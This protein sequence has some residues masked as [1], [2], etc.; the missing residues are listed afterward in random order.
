MLTLERFELRLRQ[1]WIPDELVAGS[2]E[3]LRPRF[4]EVFE[5]PAKI[6]FG[7]LCSSAKRIRSF[8]DGWL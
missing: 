1:R 6:G 3:H 8:V 2:A 7:H 4:L 5:A